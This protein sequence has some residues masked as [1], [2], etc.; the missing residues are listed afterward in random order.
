MKTKYSFFDN[1]FKDR[2]LSLI[3]A[4]IF[5]AG[6]FALQFISNKYLQGDW[7]FLTFLMSEWSMLFAVLI[8]I[9]RRMKGGIAGIDI[10]PEKAFKYYGIGILIGTVMF[11]LF[12]LLAVVRGDYAVNGLAESINWVMVILFAI[13]FVGQGALEEVVFRG[14]LMRFI[15]RRTS[16]LLGLIISSIVFSL[17]HL[18]GRETTFLVFINTFLLAALF[19]IL[20][21]LTRSLFLPCGLHF[22]WNFVEMVVFNTPN[23]SKQVSTAVFKTSYLSNN[24]F[25]TGGTYGPEGSVY[26]TIIVLLFLIVSLV[27]YGK[28]R[29][30][31]ELLSKEPL[32]SP[33]S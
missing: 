23:S 29:G 12:L 30:F 6:S 19:S 31:K 21:L 17:L 26:T 33:A 13:A 14:F 5:L 7:V 28:K 10:V 8:F 3:L 27:L 11:I 18:P 15:G 20:L 32:E 1:L 24:V 16:I 2:R 9:Q 22:A 4:L 25:L